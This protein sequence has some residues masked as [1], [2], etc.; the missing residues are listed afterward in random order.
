[1]LEVCLQCVPVFEYVLQFVYV[2]IEARTLALT[3]F[4]E[5]YTRNQLHV[6]LNADG[7]VRNYFT[8]FY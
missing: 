7:T 3:T 2:L 8:L 5:L 4:H 6:I 1:M